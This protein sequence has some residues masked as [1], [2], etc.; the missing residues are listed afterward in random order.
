MRG[1][2]SGPIT[3]G[4]VA[5]GCPKNIIDSEKML[6]ELAQAGMVITTDVSE[7]DVAVINT[8][9]FIA[10]AKAE[11]LEEIRRAVEYKK[12]GRLKRVVVAGCLPQRL[13]RRLFEEIEGIDAVVG[14]GQR[15]S[16]VKVVRD[17]LAATTPVACLGPPGG[18][19]SDDR[20]RLRITPKHWA[21]LRISEGCNHRCSFCTIPAIR[22]R[23]RSKPA[24]LVVAEASELASAGVVELCVVGQD[25]TYYGRDLGETDGLPQLLK[26]LEQIEGLKWLRLLYLNPSQISDALI[27]TIAT[28]TKIVPYMDIPLQHISD[29][30]LKRMHR[31]DTKEK[32]Y[33]LIEKIRRSIPQVVLRT[34]FIV[35]FPGET[36]QQF[37]ELL[38]FVK[39]VRFDALGCFKFY[40]EEGTEAAK[41]PSQIPEELKQSRME[42]LMLTQQQIAFAKNRERLG[43]SLQCLVDTVD[44]RGLATGRFYAQAPEID[45]HCIIEDCSAQPGKFIEAEVVGWRGY[46]LVVR[47]V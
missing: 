3:V 15:D 41:M 27:E 43:E 46:D 4:F 33:A 38:E 37:N 9:G 18:N 34:T 11:A 29:D 8:C 5:L 28:S 40:A 39:R 44:R 22:G 45:S 24:E 20:V 23:Y 13:G 36:E 1:E 26:R 2:N 31:P 17:S 7:A 12:K 32:I 25:V 21:Y 35:G 30:I 14:L 19:V 47:Q 10:P 6:A 42:K 16:I